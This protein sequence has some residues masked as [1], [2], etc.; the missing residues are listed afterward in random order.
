[1]SIQD[2]RYLGEVLCHYGVIG[3]KWGVRRSPEQLGH[4]GKKSEVDS[5]NRNAK[6]LA[7]CI[8]SEK[9][10]YLHP[11]KINKFCLGE[12]SKHSKEF[13]DVGYT[14]GDFSRLLS[15]IEANFDLSRKI[16]ERI[17]VYDKKEEFSIPM[18]L[19]VSIKK[20]F[21]TTWKNDVPDG[22]PRFIGAHR[23]DDLKEGR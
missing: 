15:D 1:M 6:L 8:H 21:R 5:L 3:M 19:G 11:D 7:E 13:F 20:M 14:P 12:G 9:G 18:E 4:G 10:F 2:N 16:D 17:S 23:E 22:S